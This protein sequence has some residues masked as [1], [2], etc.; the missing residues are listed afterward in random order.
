MMSLTSFRNLRKHS[1]PLILLLLSLLSLGYVALSLS[2]QARLPSDGVLLTEFLASGLK[3]A[4][5]LEPRE[6]ALAPGD[7]IL[8]IDGLTVWEWGERAWQETSGPGWQVGQTI[9]YQVRREQTT[10][11]VPVTLRPFPVERLPLV[12]FGVYALVITVLIVGYFMLLR[13]PE[14]TAS[15]L[16]F[17][18]GL[19]LSL[20]LLLH[21]QVMALVVPA[22]FILESVLKF[23]A[24][25]FLF[26]AVCHFLLIFPVNKVTIPALAKHLPV[27]HLVNPA[28]SL[29]C[30]LIFGNTPLGEWL[31][32]SQV[33]AWL[34]LAMLAGGVVSIIHTA[35]TVRKP[36]VVGQI[37]WIAWGAAVGI[38]PYLLLTGLPELLWGQA[39]LTIEVT[40]FFLI[41]MPISVAI[42]VVRYRL[43]DVDILVLR[44]FAYIL[45]VLVLL[46]GYLLS[47]SVVHG[48]LM[49]LF[50]EADA[51]HV[52][53]AAT[54]LMTSVFWVF[55]ARVSAYARRLIYRDVLDEPRLLQQ[56]TAELTSALR[57]DQLT[58]LLTQDLPEQM[59]AEQGAL[60]VLDEDGTS[61]VLCTD[62]SVLSSSD[63]LAIQP[64]IAEWL[65]Q[66]G[67]PILFSTLPDWASRDLLD[68]MKRRHIE[69][70]VLLRV[71]EHVVG[72]WGLGSRKGRLSYTTTD[73]R[74]ITTLA[75]QAAL[76]VENVQLVQRMRSD[77]RDLEEEVRRRSK[78]MVN[79]RN[80]LSAILQNMADALLVTD[81]S[82]RIQLA[83][84][85]FERLV[86]QASRSFLGQ[87]VTEVLPLPK[88]SEVL[89]L[90]EASPGMIH[91]V[92]IPMVAPRLSGQNNVALTEYILRVSATALGDRSAVI[93]ILRD[94]THEVEVDRMKSEFVSAVS[95]ELRTPLTS[96]VGF[97][98]LI[99]RAFE[100]SIKPVLPAEDEEIERVVEQIDH[101]LK[102]MVVEGEHLTTIINDVLDISALD[103]GTLVWNDGPCDLRALVQDVVV[104]SRALT[105][106]KGLTLTTDFETE[107]LPLHADCERIRQV[108]GNLISNAIKFTEYGKITISL[109]HLLPGTL[110]YGWD[111]PETG[112]ALAAVADTGSGITAE[113]LPH[114][115]QRFHQVGDAFHGKPKGTGLGLA[116]CYEI[117]THYGGKIWVESTVGQGSTFYFML[118]LS[119]QNGG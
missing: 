102:I 89:A 55:R 84:P 43:F 31:L 100:R 96:I 37:R 61:L 14:A 30:G 88:L 6:G 11:D 35:T 111:V 68:F 8:S 60:M 42:A 2:M 22:L 50:G 67:A 105:D 117:V 15:R 7:E 99:T 118:P 91:T 26:S 76:A 57:L 32:A 5:D 13:Y 74:L 66:G 3:V 59:A 104:E 69:L 80:R 87:N 81:L 106:A 51:T 114:I 49:M 70:A 112:A 4:T 64:G 40:A 98:K 86:R 46:G 119:E 54:F 23:L 44:T 63:I 107:S 85:A 103:A 16:I 116:I 12:R 34:G 21:F 95:H 110:H 1:V 39:F 71:G 36:A 75:L 101:N 79:D 90:A 113:G 33:S 83:N 72:L 27:L 94:I 53:F 24:R 97:A 20:I 108:L 10:L 109:K 29:L 52:V 9:L 25:A 65:A 45:F 18:I 17:G 48:L 56:M 77:Q 41:A 38:L 73:I 62:A 115:F 78:A 47:R 92:N 58:T 82:G 19:C 28:F 93:F